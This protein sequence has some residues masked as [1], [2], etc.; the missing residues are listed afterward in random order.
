MYRHRLAPTRHTVHPQPEPPSLD[1]TAA[2]TAAQ[3][4]IALSCRQRRPTNRI[5]WECPQWGREVAFSPVSDRPRDQWTGAARPLSGRGKLRQGRGRYHYDHS[6]NY[7][8]GGRIHTRR[9]APDRRP[10]PEGRRGHQR[11]AGLRGTPG[12]TAEIK[13][14]PMRDDPASQRTRLLAATSQ[15]RHL[16][17][18]LRTPG[19]LSARS[20]ELRIRPEGLLQTGCVPMREPPPPLPPRQIV[21]RRRRPMAG[22][23]EPGAAILFQHRRWRIHHRRRHPTPEVAS[24]AGLASHARYTVTPPLDPPYT[25]NR[26]NSPCPN[27]N[28]S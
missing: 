10:A 4:S 28:A 25:I 20:N 8:S 22:A 6:Q 1:P 24:L 26:R 2:K 11:R 13:I 7:R 12:S 9:A 19:R 15:T 3:A 16:P 21:Q 18:S 14:V 17:G 23:G 27:L 5:S